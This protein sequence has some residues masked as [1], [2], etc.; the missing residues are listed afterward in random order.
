M[1]D[2][3]EFIIRTED[4]RPEEILGL[5]VPIQR[6]REL[7]DKLKSTAP[8]IIEGSRGTGKSLLLRVC[9]QEQFSEFESGRVLPIYLSFARSSLLTTK[10]GQQ[11]Q[12]WMLASL[13]SR[14]VRVLAQSGLEARPTEAMN[15]L[16]G[17]HIDKPGE[18]TK[19]DKLAAEFE[20]S[21][22]N[23]GD[24][25]DTS[26]VPT[27]ER[28]R[29]AVEDI[30]RSGNIRRFNVLFDEAAHIFRPE[31]QRQFFTLFRDLRSPFM[32][33]NAAVYPGV[34]SYGDSFETIHDAQVISLNRDITSPNYVTQM[35]EI[36]YQQAG[37]K[38]QEEISRNGNNFAALAYAVSGN[39][40]LLLKTIALAGTVRTNDVEKV[41]K[42]FFREAIWSEHSG[43]SERYPGHK[44]L[45]D[46][47]RHF[48]ETSV[49]AETNKKNEAWKAEGKPERTCFFW[50]HRDA[51]E[52][53]REA[54]RLLMYTGI[55]ARLDSGVIATRRE[56]GT[57]YSVNIGCL[58]VDSPSPIAYVS[59]LRTGLAVKRFTEYGANVA[60]FLEIAARVGPI[61]E[62]DLSAVLQTLLV[63]PI[64][65]L[66][67]TAHQ[68]EALASIGIDTLGKA[69]R[70][71][72]TDFKKAWYIGPKRSR[73]IM[74][75]VS[76]AV[77]EYLSG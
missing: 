62:A 51:P 36:V 21:Y 20:A 18:K 32:T 77:F 22:K 17:G 57:R 6:D 13:C 43:L 28:F 47:G 73:Q 37:S 65:V 12:H 69:L 68:H 15:L 39:P 2:Q 3:Q 34:T 5:F 50:V 46:W 48:I 8:T 1:T 26:A 7:V 33:C 4:V 14:I 24:S 38:L 64:S 45:I 58:A 41:I 29:E 61:V 67:L 66:D 49:I 25:I 60:S 44:A 70:S 53:A 63:K 71:S 72:E 75:V 11:F 74:N 42:E 31:Q 59:D 19:L 52:A 54:L 55:V 9:E 23:P 16:T 56:L 40:R 10:D 27:I 35:R 76:A 30:C